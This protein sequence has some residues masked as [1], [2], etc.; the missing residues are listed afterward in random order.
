VSPHVA[1]GGFGA[2]SLI[3]APQ[4]ATKPQAKVLRVV[5]TAAT[6]AAAKETLVDLNPAT[7]EQ[8]NAIPSIGLADKIIAKQEIA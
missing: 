1:L 6:K 7:P 5:A 3:A 4:T 2:R 8:L